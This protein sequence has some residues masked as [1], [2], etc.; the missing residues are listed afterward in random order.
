[1]EKKETQKSRTQIKV[2]RNKLHKEIDLSVS[3]KSGNLKVTTF[4]MKR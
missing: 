4:N 1:M 2:T 3:H